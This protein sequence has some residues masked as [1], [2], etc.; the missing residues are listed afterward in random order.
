MAASWT[1]A[2]ETVRALNKYF[3]TGHCSW[4]HNLSR[5]FWISVEI[6]YTPSPPPSFFCPSSIEGLKYLTVRRRRFCHRR[7]NGEIPTFQP[8]FVKINRRIEF[9]N[10]RRQW[11]KRKKQ[12]RQVETLIGTCSKDNYVL[13]LAGKRVFRWIDQKSLKLRDV[14]Y[15]PQILPEVCF[16]VPFVHF[17]STLPRS[18]FENIFHH[19]EQIFVT[20]AGMTCHTL[21]QYFCPKIAILSV[22]SIPKYNPGKTNNKFITSQS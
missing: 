18:D 5:L 19:R 4:L 1:L 21:R 14:V 3:A 15:S 2:I 9:K 16:K 6:E 10:C 17:N 13:Y 12:T 8:Y 20:R 11:E 22:S 7:Y